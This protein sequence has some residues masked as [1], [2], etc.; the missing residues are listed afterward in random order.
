MKQTV[1]CYYS[2]SFMPYGIRANFFVTKA[3]PLHQISKLWIKYKLS[4]TTLMLKLCVR[5]HFA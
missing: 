1:K 3:M 5:A 4:Y 2:K